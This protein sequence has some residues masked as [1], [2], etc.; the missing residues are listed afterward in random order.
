MKSHI[1]DVVDLTPL[2]DPAKARQN[3]IS[4][5][6]THVASDGGVHERC[7]SRVLESALILSLLRSE[8]VHQKAQYDLITYLTNTL[9][10]RNITAF[11]RILIHA[12]LGIGETVRA[13]DALKWLDDYDHFTADRKQVMLCIILALLGAVDATDIPDPDRIRYRNLAPW[14][15][16]SLCA[17][18]VIGAQ[19]K[20]L[21]HLVSEVDRSF[22][23]DR[24]SDTECH[25]LAHLLTLH[26]HR[27]LQPDSATIRDDISKLVPRL[28]ADGGMPFICEMEVFCTATAGVALTRAGAQG[29][30]LT[31][32]ADYLVSLQAAEG[33]WAFTATA[34][35]CDADDTAYC[36]EFLS[37]FDPVRYRENI[38]AGQE[39]LLST[40]NPDGGFP[41][42]QRGRESEVTMTAGALIALA[43]L[44]S[45][46]RDTLGATANFL[47]NSQRPD[48]TFER[49][50]SLSETN[51][52]FRTAFAI[53]SIPGAWLDQRA[54]NRI[55]L[56]AARTVDYLERAQ[57][58]DGG[59]GQRVG[60]ASDVLST[61]YAILTAACWGR[62][63]P[64]RRGLAYLLAAQE[65]DGGF[66]S[67]P[68]QSGPRPL[69]YDVPVLAD[70]FA[71]TALTTAD[72]KQTSDT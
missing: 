28:N 22:L 47:L 43:P 6:E 44:W 35:L 70:I 2:C 54:R 13:A 16:V 65:P 24:S 18:K 48:G 11:D 5:L 37:E 30:M 4:H 25:L 1:F 71:L 12:A 49:S 59:W 14:T 52:M 23:L 34:P 72:R 57:N 45:R 41:T 53:R 36:V 67:I 69:P 27:I 29:P 60:A 17:L 26:A 58:G 39:Y 51:A 50:W 46:H 21:P 64:Q 7:Q 42:F 62:R 68:D 20:R 33:G 61:S 15:A 8:K 66:S 10:A 38:T 31:R 56:A 9:H 32:M 55:S 19:I 40:A 3:L 63:I